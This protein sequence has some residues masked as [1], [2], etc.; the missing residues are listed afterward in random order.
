[1]AI[2]ELAK[3]DRSS[4]C[5]VKPPP[6][7][8]RLEPI[9]NLIASELAKLAAALGVAGNDV[10]DI[11]QDVYLTAMEQLPSRMNDDELRRWL[12]RVTINRC[13]LEHRR[14]KSWKKV[15]NTMTGWLPT[16]TSNRSECSLQRQDRR[17]IVEE[18]IAQLSPDS[19]V[20]LVLRYFIGLH[21][22]EIGDI[23]QCSD[24]TV[25]SRLR[26]ARHT[27]AASLK[28]TATDEL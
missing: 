13:R 3:L 11:L 5:R 15:W 6:P 26:R 8:E 2:A 28:E 9:W 25:R 19:Q 27:L 17:R 7:S 23:L 16:S 10:D 20:V 14:R 12:F 18:A 4:R 24:S 21:S 22:R 1:M